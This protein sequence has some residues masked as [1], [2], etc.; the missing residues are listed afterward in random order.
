MEWSEPLE[1]KY[2]SMYGDSHKG[3]FKKN[4][5]LFTNT[6]KKNIL[7]N[8]D[9]LRT[10]GRLFVRWSAKDVFM[11]LTHPPISN[12]YTLKIVIDICINKFFEILQILFYTKPYQLIS[13][14]YQLF[15]VV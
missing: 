1:V 5:I 11:N 3:L 2:T 4:V 14:A 12:C 9:V 15:S 13:Y 8:F 10:M 6:H 7:K